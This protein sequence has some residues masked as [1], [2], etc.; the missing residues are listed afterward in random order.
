MFL[1]IV[2]WSMKQDRL[3]FLYSLVIS[4]SDKLKSIFTPFYEYVLIH[5][6]TDMTRFVQQQQQQQQRGTAMDS[7]D[8]EDGDGRYV[9]QRTQLLLRRPDNFP[10]LS[11]IFFDKHIFLIQYIF[12]YS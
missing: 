1:A 3:L 6:T 12:M 2:D 10:G 8:E 5:V 4:L 9:Q 7:S 11:F